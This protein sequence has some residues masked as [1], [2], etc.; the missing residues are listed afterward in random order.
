MQQSSTD[1]DEM[2]GRK[3]AV[4]PIHQHQLQSISSMDTTRDHNEIDSKT[5]NNN[6]D[7]NNNNKIPLPTPTPT[8]S[9]P[10]MNKNNDDNPHQKN[11]PLHLKNILSPNARTKSHRRSSYLYRHSSSSLSDSQRQ[12]QHLKTKKKVLVDTNLLILLHGAG[13]DHR[14]YHTFA[15]RMELPQTASLSLHASSMSK[16]DG[17][18]GFVTL[19]FGLGHTWFQ[20]MDYE[21]DGSV[22]QLDDKRRINSLEHAVEKLNL[23]IDNLASSSSSSKGGSTE[24][25]SG[26]HD[27]GGASAS[28]LPER[29]FLFGFSAGACLAMETCLDRMRK[30]RRALGGVVCV[31]G[32]IRGRSCHPLSRSDE[33]KNGD[34]GG[35]NGGREVTTPVLI[36]GRSEDETFPPSAVEEAVRGYNACAATVVP[37]PSAVRETRGASSYVREGKGHSMV[38]SPDEMRVVMK[39]FSKRLVRWMIGMEGWSEVTP[40]SC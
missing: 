21:V 34:G 10:E 7:S 28:W 19:P 16:E 12:Q 25:D 32:G 14:P 36:V 20:E 30:G 18:S 13:D 26:R 31:A 23:L 11:L 27:V 40:D 9:P 4:G 5:S 38:G 17:S 39:F 6:N 24:E 33:I 15:K 2:T 22:L 3:D 8:P 35:D 29:I 37:V 1:D